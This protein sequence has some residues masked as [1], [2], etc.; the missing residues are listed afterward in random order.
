[1]PEAVTMCRTWTAVKVKTNPSLEKAFRFFACLLLAFSNTLAQKPELVV[2]TG[3]SDLISF[4]AFSS[5]GQVLASSSY[6]KT[7]KLWEVATG[8]EI[9]TLEGHSAPVK[10]I[11][12]SNDG[13]MLA[14][15]SYDRTIKLW[16]TSRGQ[17]LRTLKGHS[18]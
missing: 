4:V 6:D 1:M 17:E 15:G 2:Q 13:K 18:D 9:R 7:I 12:V 16:D 11:A 5:D 14:S 3:H 10:T 8:R